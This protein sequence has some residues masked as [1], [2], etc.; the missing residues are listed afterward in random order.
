MVMGSAIAVGLAPSREARM[1]LG[2][3]RECTVLV[4]DYSQHRMPPMECGDRVG[5]H[6]KQGE[7]YLYCPT[8]GYISWEKTRKFA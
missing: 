8:H 2:E 6:S 3:V 4:F 5:L 1:R 7:N